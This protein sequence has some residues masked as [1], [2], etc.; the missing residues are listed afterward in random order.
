MGSNK[1]VGREAWTCNDFEKI[2]M[3]TVVLCS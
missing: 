3:V 1:S 2:A